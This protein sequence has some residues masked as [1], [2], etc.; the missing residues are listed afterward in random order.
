MNNAQGDE[1]HLVML[2]STD[3]F[4]AKQGI[5]YHILTDNEYQQTQQFMPASPAASVNN[6]NNSTVSYIG[7]HNSGAYRG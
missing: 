2:K 3:N 7:P 4:W 5:S 6:A 1:S